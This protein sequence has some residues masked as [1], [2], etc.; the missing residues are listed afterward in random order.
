MQ[1][2]RGAGRLARY[3][4]RAEVRL[5]ARPS[6]AEATYLLT[7]TPTRPIPTIAN[8]GALGAITA[9]I[10]AAVAPPLKAVAIEVILLAKSISLLSISAF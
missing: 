1:D 3:L 2:T 9:A 5:A 7:S 6:I 8:P 10:N 4:T